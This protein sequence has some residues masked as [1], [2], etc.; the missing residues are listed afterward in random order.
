LDH[1]ELKEPS[2]NYSDKSFPAEDTV[3]I[4]AEPPAT[5]L[6]ANPKSAKHYCNMGR[7]TEEVVE[8]SIYIWI[9]REAYTD[10]ESSFRRR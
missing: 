7:I 6:T 2:R 8:V 3:C 9:C 4:N 5:D 1:A 10:I